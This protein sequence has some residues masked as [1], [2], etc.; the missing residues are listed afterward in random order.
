[1]SPSASRL[2]SND[3]PGFAEP[4]ASVPAPVVDIAPVSGSMAMLQMIERAGRDPAFDVDKFER[5][6]SI[7]LTVQK[8]EDERIE[9]NAELEAEAAFDAALSE[10]QGKIKRVVANQYN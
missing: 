4:R 8:Q 1:M 3:I 7:S 10:V 6:V 5:L 9:R 2:P